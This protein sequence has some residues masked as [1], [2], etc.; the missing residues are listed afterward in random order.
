[1]TDEQTSELAEPCIGSFDDPATFVTPQLAAIVVSPFLIVVP[2]R[3]NQFD[4]PLLPPLAQGIGVIAR[5]AITR[6]GFCR[7]RPLRRGT[8]TSLRVASASV[9]SAGEALSSRTPNGIP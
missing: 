7:G 2:I 5:S 9:T 6:F 8:R 3:S 1:M 4:A